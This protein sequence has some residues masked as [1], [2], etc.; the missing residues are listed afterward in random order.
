MLFLLLYYPKAL[1]LP[2]GVAATTY[3]IASVW[4]GIANFAAG[5]LVDRKHD[6]FRYE[7][8]LVAGA[9]PLGLT[10]ELMYLPPMAKG[11]SAV[12][13]LFVAHLLFTPAY[14]PAHMP[15]LA[16]TARGSSNPGDRAFVARHWLLL[17]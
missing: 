14:A 4:D 1:N 12:A 5:I 15:Y 10:F 9:V 13:S 8:L 2:T 16:M 6:R 7:P 11:G 3:M 17:R